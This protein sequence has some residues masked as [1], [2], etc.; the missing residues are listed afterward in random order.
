MPPFDTLKISI[1]TLYTSKNEDKFI[2]DLDKKGKKSYLLRTSEKVVGLNSLRIGNTETVIDFSAKILKGNYPKLLTSK[3][4]EEA[5]TNILNVGAITFDVH[6]VLD[7]AHAKKG[8]Q[9]KDFYLSR[10]FSQYS[11]LLYQLHGNRSYILQYFDNDPNIIAAVAVLNDPNRY[12]ALLK[13]SGQA[14]SARKSAG[15]K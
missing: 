2:E 9:A 15:T 1:P 8:H 6:A 13:P 14:A 3:T 5:L 10:S 7:I 12:A 11:E 4:I